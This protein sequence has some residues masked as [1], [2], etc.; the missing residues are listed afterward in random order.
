MIAG[1]A[2]IEVSETPAADV[3]RLGR[4]VTLHLSDA[5]GLTQFGVHDQTLF[6]GATTGARHWHSAEDEFA[7]VLEGILTLEDDHGLHDLVP[8]DAVAWPHGQ[9]NGHRLLNRSEAPCRFLVVGSRAQGDI[10]TYPGDGRRQ[11]HTETTW[12][13]EAADG[14]VL[15]GGALPPRLLGL[16]APWGTPFDGTVRPSVLRAGSVP[17]VRCANNYPDPF[18]DLGEAEDIALS[19]AGGLTQFGAFVEILHPG[20][21]TSLRHWHEA[22][23]EFLYVL[24]GTVTLVEDD[25]PQV[26][27]PGTCVCWPAGVANAHCLRN[28]GETPVSLFIVGTRLPEDSCHY[29]DVDLHYS[30]R[31]GQRA[32]TRKDGSPYPGWPRKVGQ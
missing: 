27:G 8:G 16:R 10:C 12:R 17:K 23:D 11:I 2:E 22:E 30:R 28:D 1:R 26:I 29:P 7:L 18:S 21:Q 6:P 15:K 3:P 24:D 13:I 14:T 20:G 25:G 19:D 5:G 4:A 31:N 32:F 9:P